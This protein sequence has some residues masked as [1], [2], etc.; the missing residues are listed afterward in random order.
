MNIRKDLYNYHHLNEH[1]NQFM[2]TA[3]GNQLEYYRRFAGLLEMNQIGLRESADDPTY[4]LHDPREITKAEALRVYERFRTSP[5]AIDWLPWLK[6]IHLQSR[7][8]NARY[9]RVATELLQ[10]LNTALESA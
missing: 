9:Q 7:S 10:A 2:P 4:A 1:R 8:M 6:N 5:E 3:V